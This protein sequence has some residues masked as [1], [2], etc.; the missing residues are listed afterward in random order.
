MPFI[1]TT[2]ANLLLVILTMNIKL[3]DKLV[4]MKQ[5]YLSEKQIGII[6]AEMNNYHKYLILPLIPLSIIISWII[7]SYI[8][9]IIGD[10]LTKKGVEFSK[11]FSITAWSSLIGM[12]LDYI[13][14]LILIL[15][16]GTTHG[17]TTSM[18][19]LL[20]TPTI[21]QK[22]YKNYQILSEI[23]FLTIWQ[24]ILIIVGLSI[25]YN[26]SKK[27]SIMIV[28]AIWLPFII[29]KFIINYLL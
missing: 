1:I 14:N 22:L 26:I 28:L 2:I 16:S 6:Q 15:I 23:K 24:L 25:L 21:G 8:F 5:N 13:I 18:A 9:N 27:K 17:V 10:K 29:I 20:H 7:I 11:I 19:I 4:L 3:N 12:A